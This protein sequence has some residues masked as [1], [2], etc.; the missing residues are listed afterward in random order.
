MNT[1]LF[2]Y[3]VEDTWGMVLTFKW[4]RVLLL[5]GNI[6]W[7]YFVSGGKMM[8]QH[9]EERGWNGGGGGIGRSFAQLIH[10]NFY[11]SFFWR[12][13]LRRKWVLSQHFGKCRT[14]SNTWSSRTTRNYILLF[15]WCKD[16]VIGEL[17]FSL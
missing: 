1:T 4:R 16:C 5:F 14:L 10:R 9:T 11:I 13:L 15:T 3:G 17:S 6:P 8:L 7:R 12:F 2:Q